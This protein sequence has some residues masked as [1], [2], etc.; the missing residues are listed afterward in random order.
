MSGAIRG[1]PSLL[2]TGVQVG[3]TGTTEFGA[4]MQFT[5]YR[6]IGEIGGQEWAI[7]KRRGCERVSPFDAG[8]KTAH[9]SLDRTDMCVRARAPAHVLPRA[10]C[11]RIEAPEVL[12][13]N[14]ARSGIALQGCCLRCNDSRK[15]RRCSGGQL[16]VKQSTA[17]PQPATRGQGA[18]VRRA[19]SIGSKTPA[20]MLTSTSS[21][22]DTS[23][24]MI[25]ATVVVFGL[26]DLG[27]SAAIAHRG[28]DCREIVR[29]AA[30]VSGTSV[31]AKVRARE[32]ALWLWRDRV[33][34]RYGNGFGVW[35][36]AHDKTV[37]C[38]TGSDR[39]VCTAEALPCRQF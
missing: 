25:G 26:V 20:R 31:I 14:G 12:H 1:S 8:R 4:P 29:G 39:T 16:S 11:G 37:T 5:R 13:Q 34:E 30:S 23:M 7:R 36:K 15:W 9:R 27:G 38:K 2:A 19:G 24:R 21:D 22:G 6:R 28:E 17:T 3:R 35:L 18:A 33:S 10:N 32:K